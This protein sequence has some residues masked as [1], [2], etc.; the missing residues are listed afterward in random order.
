MLPQLRA[1]LAGNNVRVDHFPMPNHSEYVSRSA[2]SR[3]NLAAIEFTSTT[4]FVALYQNVYDLNGDLQQ[5]VLVR[6]VDFA[7]IDEALADAAR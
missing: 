1:V 5:S 3:Y 2:D 7:E 6:Y 4:G